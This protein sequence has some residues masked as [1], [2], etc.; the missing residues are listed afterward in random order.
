MLEDAKNTHCEDRLFSIVSASPFENYD[1]WLRIDESNMTAVEKA[2]LAALVQQMPTNL[3][4][5]LR[6]GRTLS[7]VADMV[8]KMASQKVLGSS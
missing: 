7:Y 5:G 3:A 6:Y 8:H 1:E 4:R 2:R